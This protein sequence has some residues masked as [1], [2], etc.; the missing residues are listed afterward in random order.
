MYF[1]GLVAIYAHLR[2]AVRTN[3]VVVV[4]RIWGISWG[5]FH[6][7]GKYHYARL[8]VYV[9]HVF[10]NIHPGS[11]TFED[12][13]KFLLSCIIALRE[14]LEKRLISFRGHG[15]HFMGPDL[16]TEKQNLYGR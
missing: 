14:V 1:I 16:V 4:D 12:I 9:Q 13:I 6:S 11:T 3:N 8:C 15:N 10:R 7:T 2:A 5:V